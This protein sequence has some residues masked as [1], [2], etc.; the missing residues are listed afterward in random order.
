MSTIVSHYEKVN[1]LLTSAQ[2][3]MSIKQPV[4]LLLVLLV[5]LLIIC[6]KPESVSVSG[7]DLLDLSFGY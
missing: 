7:P 6:V 4:Y 3:V 2:S 1:L 5:H